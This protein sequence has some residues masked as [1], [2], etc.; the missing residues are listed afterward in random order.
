MFQKTWQTHYDDIEIIVHNRWNFLG[1][2]TEEVIIDDKQM[3]Y[4][5]GNLFSFKRQELGRTEHFY[6][7]NTKITVKLGN[8]RYGC[9]VACQ[10]LIND[11]F[12]YG[13][14]KVM[15]AN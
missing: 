14:D 13:D 12:Y 15:F 6:V 10:I 3:Y 8:D 7:N 9:G 4:R 1:Q 11:E 5:K 2:T